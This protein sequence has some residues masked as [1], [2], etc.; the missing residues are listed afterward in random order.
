MTSEYQAWL[1]LQGYK[2]RPSPEVLEVGE[3]DIDDS[4]T[5]QLVPLSSSKDEEGEEVG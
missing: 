2:G 1:Y 5:W 3:G 4:S